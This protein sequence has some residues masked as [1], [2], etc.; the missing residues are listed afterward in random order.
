MDIIRFLVEEYE[1]N[2]HL[3]TKSGL[4][5]IHLAAQKNV[6]LPIIYFRDRIGINDVDASGSTPL[7]WASYMGS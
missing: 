1:V 5:P 2:V 3:T 7:H 6:V 4:N